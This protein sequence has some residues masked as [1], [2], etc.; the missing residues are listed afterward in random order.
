MILGLDISTTTIGF[1]ILDSEGKVVRSNFIKPIGDT[2]FEK[3][4]SA[5]NDFNGKVGDGLKIDEIVAEKPNIMFASGFSSA[6]TLA[7][8]LRFNGA[9]LFTLYCKFHILPIEVMAVSARKSVIGV[10]RFKSD[11]KQAVLN[12]VISDYP[13]AANWPKID[14]GKNQ[15]KFKAECFDMADSYVIAKYGYGIFG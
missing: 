6:Q 1:T 13:E 8:I 5:I 10:G 9:F 11:P 15:G 12:W 7:T 4:D 2:M 3:V 14:K